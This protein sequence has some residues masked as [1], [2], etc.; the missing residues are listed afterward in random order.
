MVLEKLRNTKGKVTICNDKGGPVIDVNIGSA[1]IFYGWARL[2]NLVIQQLSK[3][4]EFSGTYEDASPAVMV[5]AGELVCTECRINCRDG[6]GVLAKGA[7]A[8]VAFAGGIIDDCK[9]HGLHVCDGAQCQ[10]N[11][12]EREYEQ[13]GDPYH[14]KNKEDMMAQRIVELERIETLCHAKQEFAVAAEDIIKVKGLPALR[15]RFADVAM[16]FKI[17]AFET[18]RGERKREALILIHTRVGRE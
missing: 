17:V 4:S 18:D 1:W 15:K 12:F 6:D 2:D 10:L 9:S 3:G 5:T 14:Y 11:G 13:P 7:T 8:R 16:E